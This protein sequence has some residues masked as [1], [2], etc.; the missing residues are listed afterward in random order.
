MPHVHK[1]V[2]PLRER[3]EREKD[4]SSERSELHGRLDRAGYLL[5]A[6]ERLTLSHFVAVMREFE[7]D[8]AS[9]N[10]QVR[11]KQRPTRHDGCTAIVVMVVRSEEKEE[12]ERE[13]REEC[14]HVRA[15]GGALD[16]PAGPTLAPGRGPRRLALLGRLPERKVAHVPLVPASHLVAALCVRCVTREPRCR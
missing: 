7:I 1:V 16:V 8:A 12:R 13:Q 6:M 15:H 14:A 11:A 5:C 4:G 9:V 10:V 2:T 3:E